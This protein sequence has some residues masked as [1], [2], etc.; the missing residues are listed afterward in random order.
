MKFAQAV[1][2][3]LMKHKPVNRQTYDKNTHEACP[4][5]KSQEQNALTSIPIIDK[6][7]NNLKRKTKNNIY[8]FTSH[9]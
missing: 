5:F 8:T 1:S 3:Q 9:S 4:M 6:N 2:S 7:S